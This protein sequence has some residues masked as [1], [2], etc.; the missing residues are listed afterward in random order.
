MIIYKI[1]IVS[2]ANRK[3]E[4][5][6][7]SVLPKNDQFIL[8]PPTSLTVMADTKVESFVLNILAD[9]VVSL[10]IMQSISISSH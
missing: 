10:L 8:Q 9:L 2:F 5:S 3:A 7:I 1:F 4:I 6:S